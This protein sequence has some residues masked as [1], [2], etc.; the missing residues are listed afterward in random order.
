[1]RHWIDLVESVN[2]IIPGELPEYNTEAK[3]LAAVKQNGFAIEH[4]KNPSEGVQ[5]VAIKDI[6]S[7]FGWILH[8]GISPSIAVQ[9]AAAIKNPVIFLMAVIEYNYPISKMILWTAAKRI[10]EQ[11]WEIGKDKLDHL[12]PDIQDY[13][14]DNI[15]DNIA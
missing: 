2:D 7:A 4:I 13:L 14:K 3:Q 9:R 12:D 6:D 10:K 5:L 1:M 11:G 8:K 15:E